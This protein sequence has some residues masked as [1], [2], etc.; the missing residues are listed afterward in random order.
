MARPNAPDNTPEGSEAKTP[1]GKF[2]TPTDSAA[3]FRQIDIDYAKAQQAAS[4]AWNKRRSEAEREA[5]DQMRTL[6]QEYRDRAEKAYL[7]YAA[8]VHALQAG[9]PD[10]DAQRRWEAACNTLSQAG[11]EVSE[12]LSSRFSEVE[13]AYSRRVQEA[14]HE[15]EKDLREA[16]RRRLTSLRDTWSRFNVE[17]AVEA[18][19]TSSL[20]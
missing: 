15:L 16:Y 2:D 12:L 17:A 20:I 13:T 3:T 1:T 7:A 18:R 14:H 5:N 8:E 11:R 6:Q 19:A 10:L 9:T 4:A